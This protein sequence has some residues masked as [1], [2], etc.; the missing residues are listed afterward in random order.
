VSAIDV[1]ARNG[2]DNFLAP[3]SAA[4]KINEKEPL[5]IEALIG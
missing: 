4:E 5:A 2:G 3:V 1:G